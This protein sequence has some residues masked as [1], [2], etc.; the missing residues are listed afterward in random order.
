[1]ATHTSQPRRAT[2]LAPPAGCSSLSGVHPSSLVKEFGRKVSPIRPD[3][4]M[5]VWMQREG[6]K[7]SWIAKGLKHLPFELRSKIDLP[8]S[9]VIEAEPQRVPRNISSPDDA[10][11]GLHSKG[12]IGR[13]GLRTLASSQ[14]W[15]SSSWC[16]AYHSRT[17][18]SAR[19]GN[20][21][22]TTPSST[23]TVISNSPYSAWKCGGSWCL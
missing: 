7:H 6:P 11:H 10:N 20:S 21:P 1:M 19:L 15:R 16:T 12:A 23:P 17:S 18:P 14:F 22:L 13:S 4:S 8:L 3:D 5:E 2:R 9:P